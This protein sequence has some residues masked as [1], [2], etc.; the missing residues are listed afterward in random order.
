MHMRTTLLFFVAGLAAAGQAPPAGGQAESGYRVVGAGISGAS[1]LQKS[2][3]VLAESKLA[4]ESSDARLVEVFNWAKRQA[5]NFVFDGDPVGPWYEAA[6]PGREAFCMRDTASQAMGAH[7]LGLAPYTKNMLRRFAEN[8]SDARD[9]CSVWEIDRFNRPAPIDYKNDAEFWYNL[10]ANFSILDCCYRMYTWTGDLTY[11]N[12]PAFLNFYDR[13][14]TDYVERW[15]LGLD[16]IMTR[17]RLLNVRGMV[18]PKKKFQAN[19]GIPGYDE[20]NKDYVLGFDVLA[21]QYKAYLAYA[22]FQ[23]ARGNQELARTCQKKAAEVKDLVNKTWW[24]EKEHNYY[25][26]LNKDHQLEGQ[27]R[28]GASRGGDIDWGRGTAYRDPD[29]VNAQ[30]VDLSRSRLEYPEVSYNKIGDIV[31]GTMGIT[32]EAESPLQSAISGYWVETVVKTLPGIG[33]KIAW[34]ELRNLPIRACEVAVRH[35][36]ERKT[37][38]TNQRGPALIWQATFDGAHETLLVNGRPAK[39][40]AEKGSDGRVTSSVRLSV[41]GGGTVAV[42]VPK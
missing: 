20:G 29:S 10:P 13:T 27:G 22:Y 12:D 21:A 41:G 30:L 32:V 42:E 39:A 34:A 33:T 17:P 36:G 23:E 37:T 28:G 4:L 2:A 16:Q 11:V 3:A 9:W 15:G 7:A 8:I 5:M 14:V 35:E 38:F 6:E 25:A 19:R 24:N 1:Q 26:R 18:D 40:R 31:N